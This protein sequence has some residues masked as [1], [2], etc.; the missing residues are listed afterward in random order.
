[1]AD[2]DTR[3][4]IAEQIVS[5]RKELGYTAAQLAESANIAETNLILVEGGFGFEGSHEVAV[6]ALTAI[7][8][9]ETLRAGTA[10][11]RIV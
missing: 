3:N 11:L 2:I 4:A 7:H 8:R 1:M 10:H 5:S 6:A 9:L